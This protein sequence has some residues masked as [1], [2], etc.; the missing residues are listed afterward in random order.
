[1]A[2]L[3]TSWNAKTHSERS[4]SED[5]FQELVEL[6]ELFEGHS[7]GILTDG[8]LYFFFMVPL[9]APLELFEGKCR[10]CNYWRYHPGGFGG[11]VCKALGILNHAILESNKV[12]V[13]PWCPW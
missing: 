12:R 4:A 10:H 8:L 11:L 6:F 1:M 7:R 13:A 9:L 3:V 5:A 2:S